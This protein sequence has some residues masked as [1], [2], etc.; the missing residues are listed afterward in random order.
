VRGFSL[1]V[2][3]PIDQLTGG[4]LYARHLVDAARAQGVAVVVRELAGHFPDA[5]GQAQAE[6]AAALASMPT[7]AV[8][9]IDGL[10]LAG[11]DAAMAREATRLRLIVMVHHP[12]A[13]E[14]GLSPAE[15]RRFATL[16]AR[17]LP[18]AA[19]VMCPSARTADAVAAYGVAPSRIALAPPGTMKPARAIVRQRAATPMRLLSVAT[20]TPRK[21]HLVL[22]E[23]LKRLGAREWRLDIVGSLTRDPDAVAAVRRALENHDKSPSVRL[24]GERPQ[25]DLAEAYAAADLFVLASYHEG[26]GMAFAE[27]M[28]WGLP[29]VA[30]T[31]GAISETVPESAGI[32]VPPGDAGALADALARVIDDAALYRRLAAGAAEAGAR[33][34]GWD[35]A[36]ARWL[37][38]ARRFLA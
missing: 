29:I 11:F 1:L 21:G 13:D 22:I 3:G 25:E 30:T 19:G 12:L 20:V 15:A 36:A 26:Y 23:A 10:A 8:A 31:G 17:L 5:D 7:G 14:T 38:G 24:L 27:A 9:V 34:P 35:E 6:C 28:A 4:Y 32:L 16:E 2:P 18:L 37:E 33:L